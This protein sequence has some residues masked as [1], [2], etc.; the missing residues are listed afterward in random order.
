M[1]RSGR[2]TGVVARVV[3]HWTAGQRTCDPEAR[4]E[5]SG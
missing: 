5:K 1:K 4:E 3:V 2:E